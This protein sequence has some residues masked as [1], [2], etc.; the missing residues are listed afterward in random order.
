MVQLFGNKYIINSDP[1]VQEAADGAGKR[2]RCSQADVQFSGIQ[3]ILVFM[4][5]LVYANV[6]CLAAVLFSPPRSTD[7][8]QS[9]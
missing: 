6:A 5:R 9:S 7:L 3:K 1:V 4:P 8:T 2:L